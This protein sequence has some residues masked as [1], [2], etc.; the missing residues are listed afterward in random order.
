MV[1]TLESNKS[2]NRKKNQLDLQN[3]LVD[4]GVRRVH[5]SDLEGRADEVG[6]IAGTVQTVPAH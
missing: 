5:Y 6:V 2:N 4:V 3:F 1:S